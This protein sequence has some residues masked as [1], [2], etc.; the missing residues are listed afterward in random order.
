MILAIIQARMGSSR[1]KGKVMRDFGGKTMLETLV[2]RIK[3][4]RKIDKIVIATTIEPEDDKI[5]EFCLTSHVACFR[6]SE[7]DVLDRFY[8][9][10]LSY[11]PNAVVRLTADCPLNS[12][13]VVD[14][15]IEKYQ[16]GQFDYFSNSNNEPDYLEDGFDTEVFSFNSLS[17]AWQD[18]N[19]LSER[20]HVTPFIKGCGKFNCG[21]SKSH[22]DYNYKL[23]VDTEEDFQVVFSVFRELNSISDFSIG[24]V[25][26]LLSRKPGLLDGNR[27]STVNAGYKK[28]IE[29]DK[30]VK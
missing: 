13:Q 27:S 16:D 15:V 30:R 22:P 24:E 5:A 14:E 3:P 25:V 23:S 9:T 18:A 11:A 10:A 4:S 6:G 17:T 28:S 29:N 2:N 12:F 7:W 1:L 20:E 21:W 19:M 26:K 8:Q